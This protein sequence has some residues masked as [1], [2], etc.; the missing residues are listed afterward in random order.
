MYGYGHATKD[1]Y[2][3]ALQS[4]QAY[5]DEVKSDQ[6]DQAAAARKEE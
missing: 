2:A 6:R 3:E 5:L 1:D 4:Y